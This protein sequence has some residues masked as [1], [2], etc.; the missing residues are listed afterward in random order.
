MATESMIVYKCPCCGADIQFEAGTDH[1]TCMYCDNTYEIDTLVNYEK[2]LSQQKPENFSWKDYDNN[3]GN[4]DWQEGE[5]NRL[6]SFKCAHCG[7]E[8]IGDTSTMASTCP[9]CDNPV[10]I[11][12]TVDGVMR[13][14]FIIP[15]KKGRKAVDTAYK[16]FISKKVLLPKSFKTEHHI[17]SIK[18]IYVPFW[19]FDADSSGDGH[20][21]ATKVKHWSDSEYYYTKTEHYS[22]VRTADMS[23]EK[24]PVDGS[25]KMDDTLMESLEPFN[26]DMAVDFNTAYLA[27]YFADRYDVDV[28]HSIGRA[29]D[30]IRNSTEEMLRSTIKGYS[31]V[32]T[33]SVNV[34][35]QEGDIHYAL[36][37]VWIANT[38]Y[39]GKNYM[40]AMNGQSGKV[41]G[42]LPIDKVKLALITAGTF[43]G[44][45]L[46]FL[47]GLG[48]LLGG[49]V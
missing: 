19:L 34:Q 35:I 48:L 23:F 27:G 30:R 39:R 7:G 17:Q 4:G 33:E 42:T 3:S 16:K 44:T 49:A 8:I 6:H 5:L 31:T 14:D 37:P 1:L 40:F 11:N 15:F 18:G 24:V 36:M 25:V 47:F 26:Y 2:G 20:F 10:V 22:V 13:P 32:V 9:Y 43:L 45:F 41:V 21:R 29:N 46:V 38:E 12:E 28:T